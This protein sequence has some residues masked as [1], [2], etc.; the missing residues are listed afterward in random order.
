MVRLVEHLQRGEGIT[1]EATEWVEAQEGATSNPH[2]AD[3]IFYPKPDEEH[4]TSEQI[5]DKALV[6]RPFEL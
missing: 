1:E 6:Y 5:V 2:V 4:L 3:L